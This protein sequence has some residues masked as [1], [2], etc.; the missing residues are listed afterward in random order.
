MY[1]I[2]AIYYDD[3]NDVAT[4]NPDVFRLQI[5][6]D[7][8]LY[9]YRLN[10]AYHAFNEQ[11]TQV[12]YEE[13]R[14]SRELDMLKTTRDET[15]GNE[16]YQYCIVNTGRAVTNEEDSHSS[17]HVNG[18][19]NDTRVLDGAYQIPGSAA[20]TESKENESY[21]V[22]TEVL[23][24]PNVAYRIPGSAAAIESKVNEAYGV[25]TEVLSMEPTTSQ[26]V[27]LRM[28]ENKAYGAV[29]TN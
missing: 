16:A 23:T 29:I 14:A 27:Q 20:M 28:I 6:A 4:A 21:G 5:P 3:R 1:N 13:K 15:R 12:L 25:N 8:H 10:Q 19:S 17:A 11:S 26:S 18:D 24:K 7:D 22:N 2:I 9:M